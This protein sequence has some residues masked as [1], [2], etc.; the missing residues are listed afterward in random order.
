MRELT[1]CLHDPRFFFWAAVVEL[2]TFGVSVALGA[3]GDV[4]AICAIVAV[5]LFA[6]ALLG[7]L[8]LT[9][10]VRQRNEARLALGEHLARGSSFELGFSWVRRG[11][12]L[13]VGI[14][15]NGQSLNSAL[16]NFVV[17]SPPIKRI[18][19][20]GEDLYRP[21]AAGTQ[22]ATSE[23]LTPGVASIYWQEANV[24]LPGYGTS[25]ILYFR[26]HGFPGEEIPISF[27]IGGDE[28]DGW[29]AFSVEVGPPTL[30]ETSG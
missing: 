5:P 28:I 26:L 2:T 3:R 12:V 23:E 11:S 20:L 7:V 10:P 4:K 22:L 1:A 13:Q 15:N 6:A 29:L 17:P 24:Q 18:Y 19:R 9:A 27:R 25:T 14:L 30:E 8:S 16:I 21:A